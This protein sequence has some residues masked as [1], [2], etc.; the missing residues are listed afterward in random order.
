MHRTVITGIGAV[1]TL[2]HTL[3][4]VSRA[5]RDGVSGIEI[6]AERKALGFRSSLTG[7]IKN[8]DPGARF[9]RKQRKTMG[10]AALFGCTAALDAV[11]DAGF[12]DGEL[13]RP[14]AGVIFGNDSTCDAADE[15]FKQ[16]AAQKRTSALGTG[17]I[18]K[19]GTGYRFV[20][21]LW[22]HVL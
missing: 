1:S 9:D 16:L 8:F 17:H 11:A 20:P 5:L 18:I 14:E 19:D 6:D 15:L 7:V 22:S 12:K 4:T 2:G 21:Q 3:D 10:Q 13:A